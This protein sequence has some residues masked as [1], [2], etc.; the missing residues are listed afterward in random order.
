MRGV[1]HE[2]GM[3]FTHQGRLTRHIRAQNTRG[4][5]EQVLGN[6][7][8]SGEG[9]GL[10]RAEGSC[11]ELLQVREGAI[12]GRLDETGR[13]ERRHVHDVAAEDACP[14]GAGY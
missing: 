14:G 8:E 4:E 7:E 2:F 5:L 6:W 10:W 9:R 11:R 3:L 12:G 13:L 1:K